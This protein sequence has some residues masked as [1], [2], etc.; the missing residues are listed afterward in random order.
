MHNIDKKTPLLRQS[1]LA[2][3]LSAAA[4]SSAQAATVNGTIYKA[5]DPVLGAGTTVDYWSFTLSAAANVI[6]DVRANE[7]YSNGWGSHPG[8]YVD[9]NGDGEIT[10]ADT[11]FRLYQDYVSLDTEVT[12]ADDGKAYTP[13]GNTDGWADGS[14]ASRDSYLSTAL[15]AGHYVIAF[16]DY[17]LDINDAVAGFNTGDAITAATGTNPFTGATG[18]DHFDYQLTFLA[19]DYD[20]GANLALNPLQVTVGGEPVQPVPVPGAVWL[21]GS[22]LAGFL[23]LGKRKTA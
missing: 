19:T 18:Q 10:L 7:G 5:T 6:I 22:A 2:L 20:T 4:V 11:Q 16:G 8:S 21:F 17:K 1:L 9:L 14:L 23:G 12:S 15:E 13:P 3:A